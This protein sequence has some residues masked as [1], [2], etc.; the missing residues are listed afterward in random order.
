MHDTTLFTFE[1]VHEWVTGAGVLPVAVDSSGGVHFLL[2][3]EQ[4]VSHWHGSLKWSGFEGGRKP[5]ESVEHAAAREFIEES[6]ATVRLTHVPGGLSIATVEECLRQEK[7]VARIV[8]CI[9][10]GAVEQRR[11]HV[12]YLMQ[13]PHD[14][15]CVGRFDSQRRVLTRM[16]HADKRLKD[17]AAQL[18]AVGSYGEGDT[19]MGTVTNLELFD[20]SVL[21]SEYVDPTGKVCARPRAQDVAAYVRWLD[22]RRSFTAE[23]DAPEMQCISAFQVRRD[24]RGIVTSVEF[25]RDYLEKH[26]IQWWS[27]K[28]LHTVCH[29]GGYKGAE[30]FRAYFL[31]VL[32]RAILEMGNIVGG[33]LE[34]ITCAQCN[35]RSNSLGTV[36]GSGVPR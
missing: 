10:H 35:V 14:A 8:L 9:N 23:F 36:C 6:M 16:Q 21:R 15:S 25:N 24:E 26:A 34:P 3:K 12:T 30:F 28:D 27:M 17:A 4:Y 18:P 1:D 20:D 11:F 31:P 5:N 32:Q 29:N 22:A 7:Y 19:D 2:G 33:S 13:V